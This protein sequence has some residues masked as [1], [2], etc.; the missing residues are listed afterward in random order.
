M[1][2][3]LINVEYKIVKGTFFWCGNPKTRIMHNHIRSKNGSPCLS[4]YIE[5]EE[6]PEIDGYTL[7]Q[8]ELGKGPDFQHTIHPFQTSML[9]TLKNIDNLDKPFYLFSG[10]FKHRSKPIYLK[11]PVYT[12]GDTETCAICFGNLDDINNIDSLVCG[13]MFHNHCLDTYLCK[14]KAEC[15][16]CKDE[17]D[18]IYKSYGLV[19]PES[20]HYFKLITCP[21]C[22]QQSI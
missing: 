17:S 8:N 7:R 11:D 10:D 16:F 1:S 6:V 13:H 4:L 3:G 2:F 21:C 12:K 14:D 5:Y 22:K 20:I 15:R 19:F 9:V 18:N